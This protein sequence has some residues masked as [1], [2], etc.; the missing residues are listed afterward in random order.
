MN[1]L[2]QLRTTDAER[3]LLEGVMNGAWRLFQACLDKL[4]PEAIEALDARVVTGATIQ[5]HLDFERHTLAVLIV[6]DGD[7]PEV[8]FELKGIERGQLAPLQ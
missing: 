8:L 4:S 7:M 3:D 2:V 6:E 5:C 1:E